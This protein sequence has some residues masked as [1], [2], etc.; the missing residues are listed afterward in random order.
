[1]ENDVTIGIPLHNAEK[2]IKDSLKSA[3]AQTYPYIDFIVIDDAGVDSSVDIVSQMQA[4]HPRGE[5][6]RLIRHAQ[7]IGIGETRNHLIIF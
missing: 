2:Y 6:I 3:L 4:E 1:M 5:N 7:N